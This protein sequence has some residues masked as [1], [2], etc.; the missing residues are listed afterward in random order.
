MS[1]LTQTIALDCSP[2]AIRPGD[3]IASVIEGT[4]LPLRKAMSKTFGCWIWDYSDIDPD[5]WLKI[6][7]ITG[8]RIKKMY[9]N[10]LIRAGSW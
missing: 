1:Y 9:A 8:N 6:K 2:G 3:L 5:T 4:G 7:D 10:H